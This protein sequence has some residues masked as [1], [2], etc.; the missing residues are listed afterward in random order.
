MK[1]KE[2]AQ[3]LELIVRKVVREEIRPLLNEVRKSSNPVI[4]ETRPPAGKQLR[5]P[6]E[7]DPLDVSHIFAAVPSAVVKKKQTEYTKNS[8]LNS[9]LNE[10]AE[11]G[12]WKTM[13]GQFDQNQAQGFNY[14]DGMAESIGYGNAPMNMMPTTDIDGRPVDTNNEQVAAVGT[15]LTKDYSALMKV[16]NAKKGR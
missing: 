11:S 15:A 5:K 16:I 13:E 2:L 4:K 12:E 8:M 9:I 6:K 10:T 1:A 14:R 7:I 3:L